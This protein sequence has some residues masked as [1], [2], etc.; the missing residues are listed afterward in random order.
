MHADQA[1]EALAELAQIDIT[2]DTTEP[3]DRW[4]SATEWARVDDD[5]TTTWR[6]RR[7]HREIR[8]YEP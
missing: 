4:P 7:G 2:D 5:G 1:R 8:R 6:T 3:A